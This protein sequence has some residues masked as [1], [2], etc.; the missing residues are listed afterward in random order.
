M[1]SIMCAVGRIDL[2]TDAVMHHGG[3]DGTEKKQILSD[4]NSKWKIGVVMTNTLM[5]VG[6]D[7]NAP[8]ASTFTLHLG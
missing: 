5:T 4:F 6:I 8:T 3:T 7:F 1:M 2:I